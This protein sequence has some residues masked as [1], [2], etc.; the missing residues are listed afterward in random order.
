MV[1][2]LKGDQL[3]IQPQ[4]AP[5]AFALLPT[6]ETAFTIAEAPGVTFAFAG[7]GGMIERLT[8]TQGNGPAQSYPRV[9]DAAPPPPARLRRTS[10]AHPPPPAPLRRTTPHP[11][12]QPSAPPAAARTA[13][14]PWPGFRGNNASGN[15]DGQGAVTE[16]N[17]E[18][19]KNVRWKTPIP[20]FTTASP[21]VWG[22]KVFAVTAIS[23]KGDKTFRTGL[24]G[25]VAPV[26]DLSEHTW[27]IYCLDKATGK[28]LWENVAHVGVPKVK[29][30]TKSTQANSTPVTDGT[31]V[32]ALFG[33]IGMLAA[34][35]MNGKP[36]WKTDVG[37]LDSGWFFDPTYQWGHSSSPI[38]HAGKVIVQ[39]DVS[40]EFVH[41][42]LRREDRQAA[43]ED[44]P[45]GDLV[46]GH[47]DG[48]RREADRH[49]RTD[50]PRLR[51]RD[52]QAA[53]EARAELR[54]HGRHAGRR[55]RT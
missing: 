38:I 11:Q 21:I 30:H 42:R 51:S 24:Y 35:D 6:S 25:D 39:A 46:V 28:I 53:M 34:W 22:D 44:G 36:L 5:Q 43:V 47:A 20:G 4:G 50:R 32:V 23:S 17:V 41:R 33:S 16:W 55:R 2:T 14:Q 40:E 12:R 8:V 15:G 52:R 7:R 27:K 26:E 29:R 19:G 10:P 37:V 54:S 18:D 3:L 45:R 31:R 48:L 49:Q 9:T 13:P 1:V